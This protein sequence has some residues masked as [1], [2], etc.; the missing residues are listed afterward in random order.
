MLINLRNALMAGKRKPTAKDYVQDGLLAMWDGI[1]NAGWGVHNA[2]ATAWK[3]LIGQYDGAVNLSGLSWGED[4]LHFT[5]GYNVNFGAVPIGSGALW[6]EI[7]L[8]TTS[9]TSFTC[10]VGQGSMRYISSSTGGDSKYV[11]FR[12]SQPGGVG[13]LGFYSPNVRPNTISAGYTADAL[14]H[15]IYT[16]GAFGA[17]KVYSAAYRFSST[18]LLM[19]REYNAIYGSGVFDAHNVRLYSRMPTADEIAHNYAIDKAR[20]G[21]P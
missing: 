16:N 7:C 12:A 1:E 8:D 13:P 15:F 17:Q 9:T 20:F 2:S 14:T 4:R 10:Y 6:I 21:L 3:D 18:G 11:A 19:N 5:S